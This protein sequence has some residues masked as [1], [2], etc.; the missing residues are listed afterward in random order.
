MTPNPHIDLTP[1]DVE[2]I[3]AFYDRVEISALCDMALAYLDQQAKLEE[4]ERDLSEAM[5]ALSLIPIDWQQKLERAEADR[6]AVIEECALAVRAACGACD[7][8]GGWE[9]A[10]ECEYCGR[11]MQAIHALAQTGGKDT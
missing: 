5:I 9:D 3:R 7:G 8:K 2:R 6:N 1:D 4:T 11:P 10:G